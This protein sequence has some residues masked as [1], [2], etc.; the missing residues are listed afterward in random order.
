MKEKPQNDNTPL[1]NGC[2][3]PED[4]PDNVIKERDRRPDARKRLND[5]AQFGIH[6]CARGNLTLTENNV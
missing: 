2:G 3:V 5:P 6:G 1:L 4:L